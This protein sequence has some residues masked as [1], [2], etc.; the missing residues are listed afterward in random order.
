[1]CWCDI[2]YSRFILTEHTNNKHPAQ[3][4][5]YGLSNT[6]L[7]HPGPTASPPLLCRW[8]R[9]RL[10]GFPLDVLSQIS[11]LLFSLL[12]LN[13]EFYGKNVR[14]SCRDFQIVQ[15]FV[16][17]PEVWPATILILHF[18]THTCSS[19]SFSFM[20]HSFVIRH[21]PVCTCTHEMWVCVSVRKWLYF[22][23]GNNFKG[24]NWIFPQ[25]LKSRREMFKKKKKRISPF[26]KWK[27]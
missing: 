25:Q 16:M 14:G 10:R 2:A 1:M 26:S 7:G 21:K 5:C 11:A 8:V 9:G 19:F 23:T 22:S 3:S 24:S 18:R 4:H 12:L 13:S 17:E 6:H 27:M 20:V 15:I